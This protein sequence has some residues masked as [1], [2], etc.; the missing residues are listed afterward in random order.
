[1]WVTVIRT[2]DEALVSL[3]RLLTVA[4]QV[5]AP[6]WLEAAERLWAAFP[7]DGPGRP[8]QQRRAVS[9]SGAGRGWCWA[10]TRSPATCWPGSGWTNVY[11]GH[12]ERYPKIPLD[13]LLAARPDLVV[14]PDEPYRFTAGDGPEASPACPR[15]W[16]AAGT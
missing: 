5:P 16:S 2:L 4:C 13:D 9:R 6:R 12:A 7:P 3:R 14:L 10:G 11:A 15:P 1:M 8:G